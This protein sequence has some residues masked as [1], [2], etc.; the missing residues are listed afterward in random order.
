[1]AAAQPRPP[2]VPKRPVNDD[3]AQAQ[4]LNLGENRSPIVERQESKESS[5]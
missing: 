2:P 5:Q 3:V 1:M 4:V